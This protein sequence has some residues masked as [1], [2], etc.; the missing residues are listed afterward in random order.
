MHRNHRY[1]RQQP[2]SPGGRGEGGGRGKNGSS[3]PSERPVMESTNTNMTMGGGAG[4]ASQGAPPMTCRC[5]TLVAQ[6][7]TCNNPSCWSGYHGVAWTGQQE[8]PR[9]PYAELYRM[10]EYL[11]RIGREQHAANVERVRYLETSNNLLQRSVH[12]WYVHATMLAR[13]LPAPHSRRTSDVEVAH[14][15]ADSGAVSY[16]DEAVLAAN[17][18]ATRHRTAAP[19]GVECKGA[20]VTT[21]DASSATS[22]AAGVTVINGTLLA[23]TDTRARPVQAEAAK[24]QAG[25]AKAQVEAAR[26]EESAAK[27][28][29]NEAREEHSRTVTAT[30]KAHDDTR[31]AQDETKAALMRANAAREE[32]K[33]A[34][35]QAKVAREETE[36]A[37]E[38][39]KAAR[40]ETEAA[41]EETKAAQ[42]EA[43]AAKTRT[44]E[45]VRTQE[46][47]QKKSVVAA[48]AECGKIKAAVAAVAA[49]NK[50]ETEA[51]VDWTKAKAGA[52]EARR[53]E[54]EAKAGAAK[55][56]REEQEAK[57][58]A[59]KARR[60]E[61][62][63]KAAHSA[64]ANTSG[65]DAGISKAA[66]IERARTTAA[67]STAPPPS[68]S[69]SPSPSRSRSRSPSPR[70]EATGALDPQAEDSSHDR[71][72]KHATPHK[73][74]KKKS[75]N[76]KK[77]RNGNGN[78]GG[79]AHGPGGPRAADDDVQFMEEGDCQQLLQEARATIARLEKT[80]QDM[81]HR[82]GGR[83]QDHLQNVVRQ[84]FQATIGVGYGKSLLGEANA[85]TA[86][87]EAATARLEMLL[88]ENSELRDV[89]RDCMRGS[90]APAIADDEL[91]AVENASTAERLRVAA[92]LSLQDGA[93][94]GCSHWMENGTATLA[95]MA[96][97]TAARVRMLHMGFKAFGNEFVDALKLLDA[98]F[99]HVACEVRA[100]VSDGTL[101][102]T[103]TWLGVAVK[104]FKAACTKDSDGG[105]RVAPPASA[106]E[107]RIA[108]L[109]TDLAAACTARA[110]LEA[111]V[112]KLR[113]A[114]TVTTEK[115]R[116]LQAGDV[117]L[118]FA[119]RRKLGLI[120]RAAKPD[121]LAAH[122]A[123]ARVAALCTSSLLR[124][125]I[126][127][128]SVFNTA[129]E[130][131]GFLAGMEAHVDCLVSKI[132]MTLTV[133]VNTALGHSCARE[134]LE[135]NISDLAGRLSEAEDLRVCVSSAY[136]TS[137]APE[138]TGVLD[139]KKAHTAIQL[140]QAKVALCDSAQEKL[141]DVARQLHAC[142]DR[143]SKAEGEAIRLSKLV[144][145][146]QACKQKL[147]KETQGNEGEK[148]GENKEIALVM[149]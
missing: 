96:T 130:Q 111:E 117:N 30:A 85:A 54:E 136:R 31:V 106:V 44:L 71:S 18:V 115:L 59:A 28:V 112:A 123:I 147:E 81:L 52:A 84:A 62:E 6:G 72:G 77:G 37:R 97:S 7:A 2:G 17:D 68:S 19:A 145:L 135:R 99:G 143:C 82:V 35:M 63:A 23:S 118:A 88:A 127:P 41:R 39:T 93:T 78:G 139:M 34:L 141:N 16:C 55:A 36:A 103:L 50:A 11:Q 98:R 65:A 107:K 142:Q 74:N 131:F 104:L 13:A 146:M 32:T 8:L 86:K 140:M 73:T 144:E 148:V 133:L 126:N 26:K 87:A 119:D 137:G 49:A 3:G 64:A 134:Q 47:L 83:K 5:G 90:V 58:G 75:K 108:A 22:V 128:T 100:A 21:G 95:D 48:S 113:Q 46:A 91:R 80:I 53:E 102:S 70:K 9:L 116:R 69:P 149:V 43:K 57:A 20:A 105:V 40:A 89:V 114:Y 124:A 120:F 25:A 79:A 12:D 101:Q 29:L 109:A 110:D 33:A 1:H 15:G 51:R 4:S 66:S 76:K 125:G 132:H 27:Q 129:A 67:E 38:E 138:P 121:P 92:I 14:A 42:G 45:V 61:Q 24:A 122:F 56:R 60:E 94:G 10:C